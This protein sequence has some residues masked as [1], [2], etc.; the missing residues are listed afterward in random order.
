MNALILAAGTGSRLVHLTRDLPKALV[1]VKG[2]PLID[3]ALKWIECLRCEQIFVVGGFYFKKLEDFLSQY[4]GNL[5]LIENKD[6]L[7]GSILTLTSALP[8]LEDS[9]VLLNVDHIFPLRMAKRFLDLQP[10][11]HEITAFVDFDRQ[12]HED[13]MK[14]KLDDAKK[15][16]MISKGLHEFD[17]GYIGITYVPK[18][19]LAIYKQTAFELKAENEDAVVENVLQKLVEQREDLGIVNMVGVR[20]LEVDNQSDLKNAERIL[21]WVDNYLD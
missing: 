20:W 12:L 9:F 2:R 17:A 10:N 19:K 13:D 3:Y 18:E 6:F 4:Q 21:R 16:Q 1:E 11:L 15:I 8:Y 7:K 14:V 5:E